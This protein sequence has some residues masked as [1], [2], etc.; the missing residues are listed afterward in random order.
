MLVND[1]VIQNIQQLQ[2]DVN[3]N[4]IE[5][6]KHKHTLSN[7]NKTQESFWQRIHHLNKRF[8]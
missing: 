6:E 3:G 7:I 2:N 1:I 5:I 4:K 8:K